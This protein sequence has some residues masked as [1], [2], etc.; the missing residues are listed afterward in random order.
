MSPRSGR[1]VMMKL[2][3]SPVNNNNVNGRDVYGGGRMKKNDRYYSWD[4]N[5]NTHTNNTTNKVD[6]PSSNGGGYYNDGSL[7]ASHGYQPSPKA[8]STAR[9]FSW[10][11][12]GEVDDTTPVAQLFD[13]RR[14][15]QN[16]QGSNPTTS[17]TKVGL[18]P[19]SPRYITATST[20]TSTNGAL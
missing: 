4:G 1:H 8:R 18:P 6:P 20:S 17:A 16:N 13:M 15:H 3:L 19:K 11:H 5:D 12:Q 2:G 9:S 14:V 10:D 7:N